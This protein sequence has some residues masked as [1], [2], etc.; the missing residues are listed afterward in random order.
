MHGCH[1]ACLDGEGQQ[2]SGEDTDEVCMLQSGVTLKSAKTAV[3]APDGNLATSSEHPPLPPDANLVPPEQFSLLD[4]VKKLT[5]NMSSFDEKW[6]ILLGVLLLLMVFAFIVV[7]YLLFS[8]REDDEEGYPIKPHMDSRASAGS[9]YDTDASAGIKLSP[10][11]VVPPREDAVYYL[12]DI[13]HLT[14]PVEAFAVLD[15]VGKQV[16]GVIV[17]EGDEDPGILIHATSSLG[18]AGAPISFIDTHPDSIRHGQLRIAWPST[19]HLRGEMFAMLQMD[20]DAFKVMRDGENLLCIQR[21]STPGSFVLTQGPDGR[22]RQ[23][24]SSSRRG[25]RM[26]LRLQSGA[27]SALVV[28]CMLALMRMN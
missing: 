9:W 27:D 17:K 15:K 20:G 6:P 10:A 2:D 26:E 23:I 5:G 19:E 18:G 13:S 12:P 14:K 11:L 28:L 21:D 7:A 1:G 4:H 22:G 24:G 3:H 25:E 16:L 8:R